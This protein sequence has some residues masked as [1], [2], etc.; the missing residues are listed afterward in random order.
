MDTGSQVNLIDLHSL[1]PEVEIHVDDKLL[2][3]GIIGLEFL[4]TEKAEIS[5]HHDTIVLDKDLIKPIPFLREG[6][7]KVTDSNHA[8]TIL[9]SSASTTQI[10]ATPTFKIAAHTRQVIPIDVINTNV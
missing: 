5:F 1:G 9:P 3:N 2:G 4:K 7:R 6:L 10:R 8:S